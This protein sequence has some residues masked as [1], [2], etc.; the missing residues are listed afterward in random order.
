MSTPCWGFWTCRGDRNA[1]RWSDDN[2]EKRIPTCIYGRG[3]QC[4]SAPGHCPWPSADSCSSSPHCGLYRDKMFSIIGRYRLTLCSQKIYFPKILSQYRYRS[5]PVDKPISVSPHPE[6]RYTRIN[7]WY[8][9][10]YQPFKMQK[11][12]RDG[13]NCPFC[14]NVS[15]NCKSG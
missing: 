10:F 8:G 9:V 11:T 1:H 7:V 3:I 14:S 6:A 13:L 5:I 4:R 12:F 2:N 15:G